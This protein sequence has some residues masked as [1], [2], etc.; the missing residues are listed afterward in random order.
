M[1]SEETLR[2]TGPA[3]TGG[4]RVKIRLEAKGYWFVNALSSSY[5]DKFP[6]ELQGKVETSSFFSI[7]YSFLCA[8]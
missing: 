4:E 6:A 7:V 3:K 5:D 1:S 8:G 2:L